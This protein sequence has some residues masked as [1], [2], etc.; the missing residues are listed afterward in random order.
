MTTI[1]FIHFRQ[2]SASH[3]S[4]GVYRFKLIISED[5]TCVLESLLCIAANNSTNLGRFDNEEGAIQHL[6]TT[7]NIQPSELDDTNFYTES[8]SY[9]TPTDDPGSET[10]LYLYLMFTSNADDQ[11]L[12]CPAAYP[13]ALQH[14]QRFN[15]KDEAI[16]FLDS[17]PLHSS[18]RRKIT[19][20]L[21]SNNAPH[22][23]WRQP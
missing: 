18:L 12:L 2:Y 6:C 7:Y 21:I 19:R 20:V 13:S 16:Q 23:P 22:D 17:R 1:K 10:S 11:S 4:N 3:Q 15:S 8:I 9:F 5:S 14:D